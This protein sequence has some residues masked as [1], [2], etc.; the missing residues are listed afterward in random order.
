MLSNVEIRAISAANVHLGNCNGCHVM[1][2]G[3]CRHHLN[4]AISAMNKTTMFSA[5]GVKESALD[6]PAGRPPVVRCQLSVRKRLVHVTR[7]LCIGQGCQ[8]GL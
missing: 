2:F 3:R 8:E 5:S 1:T 6:A 4:T 7:Y